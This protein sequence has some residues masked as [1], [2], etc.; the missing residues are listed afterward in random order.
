MS[1][2]RGGTSAAGKEWYLFKFKFGRCQATC[3][4]SPNAME[5][6]KS[7][8]DGDEIII[9]G[10]LNI[11][12]KKDA[13]GNW[14][15]STSITVWSFKRQHKLEMNHQGMQHHDHVDSQDLPF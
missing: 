7:L 6:C 5:E 2:N 14:K 4:S 12:S 10:S 11:N 1:Y 13:D 8:V 15:E 3:F 9:D